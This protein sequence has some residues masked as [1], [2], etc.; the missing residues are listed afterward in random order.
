MKDMKRVP[1]S[2]YAYN[3]IKAAILNNELMSG[4]KLVEESLAESLKISRI[5]IRGALRQ[6]EQEGFVT[7][8]PQRGSIVSHVSASLAQELYEVREVLSG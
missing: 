3:K 1:V 8:Y 4:E 6:L 2:I 7:Y 5:P